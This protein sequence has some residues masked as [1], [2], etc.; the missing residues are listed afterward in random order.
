MEALADDY[1]YFVALDPSKADREE[2][3]TM[4][5]G[6]YSDTVHPVVFL[7]RD[8][9]DSFGF[10][11]SYFRIPT[12]YRKMTLVMSWSDVAQRAIIYH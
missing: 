7:F 5:N 2:Y 6:A 8:L 10:S 4:L 3:L 9:S 11:M 1:C 12:T